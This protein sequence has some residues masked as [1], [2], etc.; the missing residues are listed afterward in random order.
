MCC[1]V[2]CA[3]CVVYR[4]RMVCAVCGGRLGENPG[5]VKKYPPTDAMDFATKYLE[6]KYTYADPDRAQ[7]K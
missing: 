3:F 4:V 5:K 2:A 7:A 6:G 1:C